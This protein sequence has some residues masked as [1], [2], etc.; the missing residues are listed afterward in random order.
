[1]GRLIETGFR[2]VVH[3]ERREGRSSALYRS[4]ASAVLH[5][6]R[7]ML[8]LT[9]EIRRCE[10]LATELDVELDYP[11]IRLHSELPSRERATRWLAMRHHRGPQLVVGSR[12]ALFAPIPG[13][14]VIIVDEEADPLYKQ[15]ERPRLH[16]RDVAIV[17]AQR[18]AIPIILS[19]RCL[20]IE[21][22]WNC[23]T[24][25]YHWITDDTDGGLDH[26]ASPQAPQHLEQPNDD[27][28]VRNQP[29]QCSPSVETTLIDLSATSLIDG[30]LS[31][32]LME[33]I[34]RHL[35]RHEQSLLFVNRRGYAPS[36]ICRECGELIRCQ[37]CRTGLAYHTAA[38]QARELRCRY[39]GLR[40]SPP[41]VC[42]TCRSYRLGPLGTGTQRAEEC[43]HQLFPQARIVRLDRDALPGRTGQYSRRTST[44]SKALAASD[45]II[46]TQLCLHQ[47]PPPRLHL[48]GVL[49]AEL[50]LSRPDF[51]AEERMLQTLMRLKGLLQ[52]V[53]SPA[54][55]LIQCRQ[56]N[57]PVFR[58][59][60]TGRLQ[61]FFDDELAQREALGYPPFSRL[62]TLRISG[63]QGPALT[64]L[65][66]R[67]AKQGHRQI[68][69]LGGATAELW[70][71]IPVM[72]QRR[73]DSSHWQ[74]LLKAPTAAEL[75]AAL[76]CL[77]RL[78]LV[79]QLQQRGALQ[80][81][82]DPL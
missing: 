32:P 7:S 68:G 22:Y 21:T 51:R 24:Q 3:E 49:N 82:V 66:E 37:N 62:A 56:P 63:R 48:V 78:P 61:E 31:K 73:N 70:G 10:Q 71:P 12:S 5:E 53:T 65:A 45:I 76:R 2:V 19:S 81:E 4:V 18:A 35:A 28:P 57:R 59:L 72:A 9:P 8:L 15:E 77:M 23:T 6:G 1:M 17:R 60:A 43:L 64:E 13:L 20:S 52:P 36:L 25:R 80:I 54:A 69:T 74:L 26:A 79:S 55:L 27:Q 14:G 33:A 16:A 67:L 75:H 40:M 50:D 42:P 34:G 44:A 29:G 41:T 11:V 58:A 47:P 38:G 30:L 39:C 46:G